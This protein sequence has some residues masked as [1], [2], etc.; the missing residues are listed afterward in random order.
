MA[1]HEFVRKHG[2]GIQSPIRRL[3]HD[4]LRRLS[5][6]ARGTAQ[7]RP[8]FIGVLEEVVRPVDNL[9]AR[10]GLQA[11]LVDMLERLL[12][13]QVPDRR[14]RAASEEEEVHVH[15][16]GLF[17]TESVYQRLAGGASRH[18]VVDKWGIPLA[19]GMVPAQRKVHADGWLEQRLHLPDE[20][21]QVGLLVRHT[22][23]RL[24]NLLKVG[25]GKHH[26]IAP[27]AVNV[28]LDREMSWHGSA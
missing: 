23:R 20:V 14:R 6:R 11:R 8:G 5:L 10:K 1:A 22:A 12:H 3:N 21:E 7:S 28:G 25:D 13:A 27:M 2:I 19:I 24:L 16:I 9:P 18:D 26:G 4:Q 15:F 17:A